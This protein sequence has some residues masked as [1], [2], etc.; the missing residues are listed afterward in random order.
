MKGSS[1]AGRKKTLSLPEP[2]D[3][4]LEDID[5]D[6]LI[7]KTNRGSKKGI[8]HRLSQFIKGIFHDQDQDRA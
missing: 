5:V 6:A 1:P 4:W 7:K 3:I 8:K 2:S